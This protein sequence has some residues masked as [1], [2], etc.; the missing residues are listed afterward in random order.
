LGI[1]SRPSRRNAR[2]EGRINLPGPKD[3][4]KQQRSSGGTLVA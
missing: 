2:I 4:I 3:V 1:F